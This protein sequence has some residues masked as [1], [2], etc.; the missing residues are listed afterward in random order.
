MSRRRIKE[1]HDVRAQQRLSNAL[2]GE[3]VG[4]DDG[5]G[6]SS[7]QMLFRVVFARASNDFEM[8]IQ[9]ARGKN[10]IEVG[11]IGSRRGNQS[12]RALDLG[13][14]QGLFLRRISSQYQP[15]LVTEPLD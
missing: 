3:R 1:A 9:S 7:D 14:P 6:A 15:I 5:V 4:R 11:G 12:R 8:G 2:P 13:L 10:D